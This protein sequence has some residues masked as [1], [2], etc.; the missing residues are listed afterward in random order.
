MFIAALASIHELLYKL[1]IRFKVPTIVSDL[2]ML[3][4]YVVLIVF[5]VL[6]SENSREMQN[7]ITQDYFITYKSS[8]NQFGDHIPLRGYV[9]NGDDFGRGI[10]E[11]LQNAFEASP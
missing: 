6:D 4:M 3:V 7:D 1:S 8:Y 5:S 2:V 10:K 11:T 9:E